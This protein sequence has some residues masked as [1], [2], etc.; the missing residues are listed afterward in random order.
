[1]GTKIK[2]RK[3]IKL[4]EVENAG[5]NNVSDDGSTSERSR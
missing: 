4:R 3:K 5:E 2:L 1:M